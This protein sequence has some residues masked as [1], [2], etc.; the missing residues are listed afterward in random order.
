MSDKTE[1]P[2]KHLWEY[3]HPYYCNEGNYY[4]NDCHDVFESWAEFVESGMFDADR[5]LNYLFRW[6]WKAW[7]PEYPED[8]PEGER[9]HVLLL[10]FVLQRKAILRSQEVVVSEADEP[11]VRAWLAECAKTT[12]ALWEPLL[13]TSPAEESA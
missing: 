12:Q 11:A 8:F 5:D 7:H 3:D 10:F 13:P 1:T 9:P 2:A 4:S 6:D